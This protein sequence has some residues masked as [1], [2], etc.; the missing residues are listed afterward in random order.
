MFEDACNRW[1]I[2]PKFVFCWTI[3][4]L[5][6]C[7]CIVEATETFKMDDNV[8][9]FEMTHVSCQYLDNRVDS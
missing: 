9:Q 8:S 3:P 5:P 4:I 7:L 2:E 1:K 6:K